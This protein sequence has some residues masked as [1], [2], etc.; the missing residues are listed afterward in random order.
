MSKD[1]QMRHFS[2]C[3][4]FLS[5]NITCGVKYQSFSE[6]LV[7]NLLSYRLYPIPFLGKEKHTSDN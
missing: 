1:V 2:R 6:N 5:R 7:Y 3:D 4:I